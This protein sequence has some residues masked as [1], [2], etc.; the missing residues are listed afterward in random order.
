MAGYCCSAEKTESRRISAETE[1]QLRRD[2]RD[3]RWEL[4]L[5]LLA[6]SPMKAYLILR[7]GPWSEIHDGRP[8]VGSVFPIVLKKE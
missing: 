6:R 8:S 3:F 1:P 2:K 7:I 5:L 4:K